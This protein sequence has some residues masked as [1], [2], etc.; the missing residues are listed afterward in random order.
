M[1]LLELRLGSTKGGQTQQRQQGLTSLLHCPITGKIMVDLVMAAD[2][3]TYER[4]AIEDVLPKF[5][6]ATQ[7]FLPSRRSL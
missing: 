3:N 6:M 5:Q 7:C 2:G 1:E 4:S